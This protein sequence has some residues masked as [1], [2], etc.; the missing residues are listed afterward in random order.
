MEANIMVLCDTNILIELYKGNKN[1][2]P[3]LK[4]IGSDNISISII[5]SA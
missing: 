3:E 1:I 2:I 5:T 4:R